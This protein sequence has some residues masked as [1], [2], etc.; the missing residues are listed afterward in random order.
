MASFGKHIIRF[1]CIGASGRETH[2][3]RVYKKSADDTSKM[4]KEQLAENRILKEKNNALQN[5][6]EYVFGIFLK[7]NNSIYQLQ[8]VNSAEMLLK[9]VLLFTTSRNTKGF[10]IIVYISHKRIEIAEIY[11]SSR[12]DTLL[13]DDIRL[14]YIYCDKGFGKLLLEQLILEAKRLKLTTIRGR[15]GNVKTAT[16]DEAVQFYRDTGF[17]VTINQEMKCA[18]IV[19]EIV[20]EQLKED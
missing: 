12:G 17:E 6:L 9:E 7:R 2:L 5:E 19:Y 10:D 4:F 15:F 11:A 8:F 20:E 3:I 1:F 18:N 14:N 13:I 16:F